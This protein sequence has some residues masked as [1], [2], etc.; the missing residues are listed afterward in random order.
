MPHDPAAINSMLEKGDRRLATSDFPVPMMALLEAS[1]LFN[2]LLTT[3]PSAAC[4]VSTSF[5]NGVGLG[6]IDINVPFRLL[7]LFDAQCPATNTP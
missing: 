3:F 6:T 7:R 1:P 5:S 2:G 4:I